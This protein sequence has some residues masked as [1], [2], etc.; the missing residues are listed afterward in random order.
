M[1]EPV[2][3]NAVSFDPRIVLR[4]RSLD[5]V[6]DLTFAYLQVYARDFRRLFAFQF[7]VGL[8]LILILREGLNEGWP[9]V[10]AAAFVLSPL[11]E[12][13]TLVFGGDHL[14]GNAPRRR[15]ALRRVLRRIVPVFLGAVLVPLPVLPALALALADETALGFAVMASLFWPFL[16]AWFLYFSAA[17]LLENLD[18]SAAFRRSSRLISFRFGRALTFVIVAFHI[19]LFFVITIEFLSRFIISF[20]LQLGSPLGELFSDFGSYPSVLAFFLA[21]PIIALARMF[22]YVDTRTRLEGWDLQVRFKALVSR[23]RPSRTQR[24]A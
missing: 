20:V 24:V 8:S 2:T 12:K 1:V 19:R 21:A 9:M 16:L 18:L 17:L 13:V 11:T 15:L 10:W 4:P 6:F 23:E 5:E 7:V 3:D 22:D 14:F